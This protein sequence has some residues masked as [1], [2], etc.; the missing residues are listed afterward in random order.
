MRCGCVAVTFPVSQKSFSTLRAQKSHETVS[1]KVIFVIIILGFCQMHLYQPLASH[2]LILILFLLSLE[3]GFKTLRLVTFDFLAFFSFWLHPMGNFSENRQLDV[4]IIRKQRD[5]GSKNA[6]DVRAFF[7]QWVEWA[8]RL[9]CGFGCLGRCGK[10]DRDDVDLGS[11]WSGNS[12]GNMSVSW[13]LSFET[14]CSL[15]LC[16]DNQGS[17]IT[18]KLTSNYRQNCCNPIKVGWPW[19]FT[20]PVRLIGNLREL[21]SWLP[22]TQLVS[23]Q[24]QHETFTINCGGN[25]L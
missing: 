18:A 9:D 2:H 6:A 3:A 22:N 10:L 1:G 4:V 11:L 5:F 8:Q 14:K 25:H 19:E 15:C 24:Y 7:S 16:P 20:E 12:S 21:S 13:G 17:Q 23:D